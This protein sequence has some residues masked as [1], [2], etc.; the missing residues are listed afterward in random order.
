MKSVKPVNLQRQQG[1]SLMGLIVMLMVFGFVGLL[2]A[3]VI[4]SYTEYRSIIKAIGVAKTAGSTVQEIQNS[5]GK[6]ADVQYITAIKAKDLEITKVN[7][8]FEI[9]FEYDKKIALVGP[10]SLLLE[11]KYSTAG[12]TSAPK[13]KE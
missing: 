9:S 7:G 6:Q 3:Q 8:D 2:A 4:P 10:A 1:L 11:Y 5:F 12:S 13:P